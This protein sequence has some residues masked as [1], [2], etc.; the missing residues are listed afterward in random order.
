MQIINLTPHEC[1]IFAEDG[2]TIIHKIPSTGVAR[3]KEFKSDEGEI[4]IA[5]SQNTVK[6]FKKQ[7][8]EVEGLPSPQQGVLFFVSALVAQR[9][10]ERNDLVVPATAVRN[11]AQQVIGTIGLC[12][13]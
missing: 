11:D 3:C 1:V 8:G 2:K 7:F 4:Q 6:L 5:G 12:K 13:P 9:S 10:P